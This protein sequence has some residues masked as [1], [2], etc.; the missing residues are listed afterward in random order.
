MK[1]G[2]KRNCYN[3]SRI[4]AALRLIW[5]RYLFLLMQVSH[6]WWDSGKIN[7]QVVCVTRNIIASTTCLCSCCGALPVTAYWNQSWHII[8]FQSSEAAVH[9]IRVVLPDAPSGF[10]DSFPMIKIAVAETPGLSHTTTWLGGMYFAPVSSTVGFVW[11]NHTF[12]AALY[13]FWDQFGA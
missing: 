2:I 6:K 8:T 5:R 7:N 12:A 13:K 4:E 11:G 3:N 1:L 9:G 10:I